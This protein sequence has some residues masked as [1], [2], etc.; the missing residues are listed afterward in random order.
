MGLLDDIMKKA[1]TDK[2]IADVAKEDITVKYKGGAEV[3]VE[4]YA[5]MAEG[6]ISK[7][8]EREAEQ[9]RTK[10]VFNGDLVQI[11]GPLGPNSSEACRQAVE[12]GTIYSLEGAV[13]GFPLLSEYEAAGGFHPNCNHDAVTTP[14]CIQVMAEMEQDSQPVTEEAPPVSEKELERE[15]V[16]EERL[17][18]MRAIQEADTLPSAQALAGGVL[19]DSKAEWDLDSLARTPGSIT[20]LAQAKALL[21]Y[22]SRQMALVPKIQKGIDDFRNKPYTLEEVIKYLKD[23]LE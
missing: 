22:E 18:K 19:Q 14:E 7:I 8:V 11:V 10:E 5:D 21:E 9:N 12:E 20:N 16:I 2:A 4:K 15:R 17:N 1:E 23:L 6:T 13:P 3:P